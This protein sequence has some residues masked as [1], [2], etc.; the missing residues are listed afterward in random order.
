MKLHNTTRLIIDCSLALAVSV[1]VW[2]A[3][4]QLPP[5]GTLSEADW[6]LFRAEIAQ[7]EKLLISAP[8]KATITYE[9]AR[10][11]ASAQQWPE[12]IAWLQKAAAFKAGLDPSR[13]RI[14][15]D[16]RETREFRDVLT[17]VRD[18]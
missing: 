4:G 8:D 9:M 14:F 12:T 18:A 17:A 10:T 11:W 16:L 5:S 13:D 6:P 2:P 3:W 7:M 15:A 1:A